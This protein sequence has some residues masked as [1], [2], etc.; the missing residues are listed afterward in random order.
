MFLL[1]II[2]HHSDAEGSGRI[3]DDV[4]TLLGGFS[5]PRSAYDMTRRGQETAEDRSVGYGGDAHHADGTALA[6]LEYE[7]TSCWASQESRD[8]SQDSVCAMMLALV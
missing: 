8:S 2:T 4:M 5:L 7:S 1:P 3:E 6:A